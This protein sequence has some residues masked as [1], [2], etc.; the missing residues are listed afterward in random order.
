MALLIYKVKQCL[1]HQL[2]ISKTAG[3]HTLRPM[4][5]SLSPTQDLLPQP[6]QLVLPHQCLL[7]E[8]PVWDARAERIY[9]VDITRHEIHFC[10][11]DGLAHQVINTGQPVGAV[12]LY[13]KDMLVAAL[14]KGFAFIDLRDGSIEWI[15][16]P[17]RDITGNRFNDGKCDPAGRF[18][19]GTMNVHGEKEAGNLYALE[20]DGRVVLK[21]KGVS[22][23]NG[24]AWSPDGRVFYFIDTATRAVSAFDYDKAVGRISNRRVVIKIPPEMGKPDG[25]TIDAEGML[26]VALWDGWGISRWDPFT[27]KL[28]CQIKLPVSRVT[29]CTFGGKDLRDLYVTSARIGLSEEELQEQPLAGSLFVFRGLPFQGIPAIAFGG[30]G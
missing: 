23:S 20:T 3:T 17:E 28:L 30:Q 26:W 16:N 22:V 24:M 9:W 1:L 4:Q 21:L 25:M 7:G 6:W 18:W 2:L 8:G 14:Q 15:G 19:A 27:G 29:S 10:A 11:A 13:K 5:N 12:A